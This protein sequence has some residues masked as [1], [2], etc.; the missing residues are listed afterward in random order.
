MLAKNCSKITL[1]YK[2]I[3]IFFFFKCSLEKAS[4]KYIFLK[5]YLIGHIKIGLLKSKDYLDEN[6][7][8]NEYKDTLKKMSFILIAQIKI[9]RR[10]IINT[11]SSENLHFIYFS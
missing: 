3:N 4:Q 8:T 2:F 10:M 11:G 1:I 7:G 5:T 6:T 9:K